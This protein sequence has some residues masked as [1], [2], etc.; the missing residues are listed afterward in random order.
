MVHGIKRS[1]YSIQIRISQSASVSVSANRPEERRSTQFVPIKFNRRYFAEDMYR[2]SLRPF[3]YARAQIVACELDTFKY[4][5]QHVPGYIGF[6][7]IAV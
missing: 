3:V 6:S 1:N 2:A 7:A 4:P 5:V